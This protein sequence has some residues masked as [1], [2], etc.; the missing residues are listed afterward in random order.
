MITIQDNCTGCGLCAADCVSGAL[1]LQNGKAIVTKECI[2]CGHCVAVCPVGAPLIPGYDMDD[3]HPVDQTKFIR[4]EALL[5]TIQARRSI[6]RYQQRPVEPE[7][8][9]VIFQA[10]R[11]TATA[12]NCQGCR[13]ILV[14]ERLEEFKKLIWAGIGELLSAAESIPEAVAPFAQMYVQKQ[15]D[16]YADFLFRNA[17]AALF[18]A[19]ERPWDAGMATQNMELAAVAQGLGMLYNGF[20]LRAA[21]FVPGAAQW[22]GTEE[23]PLATCMLLGYPEVR[24]Q[25]TAPRRPADIVLR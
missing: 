16:P 1:T 2:H 8:L 14:Q 23:K 6:R 4:P 13:F 22:L 9:N 17:P 15:R 3:V 5:H 10:G 18:V 21:A 7:K 25:R 11:Y 24:Y 19:A 20:L 12:V